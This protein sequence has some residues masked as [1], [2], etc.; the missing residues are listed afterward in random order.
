MNTNF[1]K[2]NLFEELKEK[3]VQYL[4]NFYF[5]HKK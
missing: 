3:K 1:H 2:K 5:A 4:R